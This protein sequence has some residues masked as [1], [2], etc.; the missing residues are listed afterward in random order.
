MFYINIRGL[1]KN[2]MNLEFVLGIISSHGIGIALVRMGDTQNMIIIVKR[3][4][5]REAS[6]SIYELEGNAVHHHQT[7]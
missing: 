4:L 5:N 2:I 6:I 1:L 3:N 7:K